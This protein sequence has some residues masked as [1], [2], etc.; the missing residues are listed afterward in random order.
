MDGDV[1]RLAM[2]TPQQDLQMDGRAVTS[3]EWLA[4]GCGRREVLDIVRFDDDF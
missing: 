1:L 4:A 3:W 2:N